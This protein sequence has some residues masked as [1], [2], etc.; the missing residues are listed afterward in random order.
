MVKYN[1]FQREWLPGSDFWHVDIRGFEELVSNL[2]HKLRDGVVHSGSGFFKPSLQD[3]AVLL[4][5]WDEMLVGGV[6]WDWVM[7]VA[8]GWV[9]SD[10]GWRWHVVRGIMMVVMITSVWLRWLG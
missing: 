5:A 10:I 7:V 1:F 3:Y 2:A 6:T 8:W 4:W 9:I